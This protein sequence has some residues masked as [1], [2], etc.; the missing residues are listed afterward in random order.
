MYQHI[1]MYLCIQALRLTQAQKKL[2][3]IGEATPM[4]FT[5]NKSL[6]F[7]LNLELCF[8]STVTD[9]AKFRGLSGL[10]PSLVVIL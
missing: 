10:S 8:Y 3:R 1:Q 6:E 9:L 4:G 2:Q 7:F 5:S